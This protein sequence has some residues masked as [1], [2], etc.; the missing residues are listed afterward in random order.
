MREPSL[1]RTGVYPIHNG[2]LHISRRALL[3]DL[4]QDRHVAVA[5]LV[6]AAEPNEPEPH[7]FGPDEPSGGNP[8][9]P[10]PNGPGTNQPGGGEPNEPER[11]G[12]GSDP[13]GAGDP[14]EPESYDGI[15][16]TPDGSDHG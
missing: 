5:R 1:S 11:H 9:E 14:N 16:Q 12:F 3:F 6:G 8:N 10:E 2:H 7:G 4:A 13:P 15:G